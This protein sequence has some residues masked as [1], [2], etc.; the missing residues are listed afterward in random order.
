MVSSSDASL[1]AS[2]A[3]KS[4]IL[5]RSSLMFRLIDS[6]PGKS[7]SI[8]LFLALSVTVVRTKNSPGPFHHLL[9]SG[10]P[11]S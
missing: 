5:L 3:T 4:G 1:T 6:A 7:F 2:K 9:P 10:G 8:S 11:T